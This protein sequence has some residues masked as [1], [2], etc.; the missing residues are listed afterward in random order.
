MVKNSWFQNSIIN[1][2]QN[3]ESYLETLLGN[4]RYT[5][6]RFILNIFTESNSNIKEVNKVFIFINNVYLPAVPSLAKICSDIVNFEEEE[7][8]RTQE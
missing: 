7:A 5:C 2:D 1:P 6:S 8:V 3:L 4:K